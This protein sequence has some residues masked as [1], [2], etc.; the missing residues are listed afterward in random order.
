M[1]SSIENGH[2]DNSLPED[3]TGR[4]NSANVGRIVKRCEFDAVFDASEDVVTDNYRFGKVFAAV[5][6]PVANCLNVAQT[7]H[8]G[9]L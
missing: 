1:K 9:D 6:D 5:D 2:L 4:A 8:L 7:V 3:L